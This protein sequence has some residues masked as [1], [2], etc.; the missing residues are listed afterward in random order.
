MAREFKTKNGLLIETLQGYDSNNL[1]TVDPNGV[2]GVSTIQTSSFLTSGNITA[3]TGA[4]GA[5]LT[6]VELVNALQSSQIQQ[7]SASDAGEISRAEVASLT[8]SLQTQIT[9]I[10]SVDTAQQITL[11]QLTSV[12]GSFATIVS[13]ASLTGQLNVRLIDVEVNNSLQSI[14]IQSL[15]AS[16]TN[17][18][19]KT[20]VES[21]SGN[22]EFVNSVN[23]SGSL[24]AP[25][26][27][28]S[29]AISAN[30]A[31]PIPTDVKTALNSIQKRFYHLEGQT[32]DAVL[33]EIFINGESNNR[34]TIATDT[35]KMFDIKILSRRTDT[36][37]ESAG[38][39]LQCVIR[40]VA[41]TV[42]QVG[43]TLKTV[44]AEDTAAW[45]VS[46]VAD[47]TNKSINIS[48]KG[49]AAKTVAWTCEVETLTI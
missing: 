25:V 49:Q 6:D 41:G 12:T 48:V 42:T 13:V 17:F 4:I 9:E 31:K 39:I 40:N 38:Y 43:S 7:L 15:S 27:V 11:S 2:V 32:T 36:G 5:R 28:Y 30:W 22:K 23:I 8:G 10:T 16:N 33:T 46:C 47:N 35:T 18:V 21:I 1:L 3:I 45:D 44:I 20:G 37:S 29:P 26:I 14:A 24:N 19:H 34:I